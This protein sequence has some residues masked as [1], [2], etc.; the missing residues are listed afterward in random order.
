MW[1]PARS[2]RS[3]ASCSAR[4]RS[5]PLIGRIERGAAT[6]RGRAHHADRVAVGIFDHGE[7][8]TPERVVGLLLH[9]VARARELGVDLVDLFTGC[10]PEDDDTAGAVLATAPSLVPLP[11]EHDAVE[12]EVEALVVHV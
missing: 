6:D 4:R 11:G 9:L 1:C 2:S 3:R 5:A 10:R 12:V 8:R 7:A